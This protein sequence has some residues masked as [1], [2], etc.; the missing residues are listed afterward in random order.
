MD[1]GRQQTCPTREQLDAL[2]S[3][4]LISDEAVWLDTHLA[5]CQ[6]CREALS[7]I[8]ADDRLFSEL[9]A[10]VH[11]EEAS[12]ARPN[13]ANSGAAQN[14]NGRTN[15]NGNGAVLEA[16][17]D[18]IDGYEILEELYRGGQ[19]VIY[20]ALQHAPRRVVVLKVLLGGSF[21]SERE[22][23]RFEREVGLAASLRHPNIVTVFESG[24]AGT[25][26]YFTMEYVKGQRLDQYLHINNSSLDDSLRLFQRI[27]R[28]VHYA[29]QHGVMH[30]DLKPGNI[31]VDEAGE[32]RVLD[33]GLAKSAT[34]EVGPS[35]RVT[36]TGEFMGTL[37]YA[38][39]EQVAGDSRRIDI[40][41]DVY[42]LGVILYEMLT[43]QLPFDTT[44]QL[45]EM[46]RQITEG[47]PARP[48][49]MNPALDVDL[50]IILLKVLAKD[51]ERRYQSAE[52]LAADI[53]RY[54]SSEPIEARRDSTWYVVRKALRRHKAPVAAAVMM[55]TVVLGFA[56]TMTIMYGHAEREATRAKQTQVF[57]EGLLGSASAEN[58]G[59]DV[60]LLEVLSGAEQRIR[61][62]LSDQPEVEVAV[63]QTIGRTYA[64]IRSFSA[65]EHHLRSALRISRDV[66]GSDHPTTADCA[67]LLGVVLAQQNNSLS[68]D[69]QR[70]ALAVRRRLFGDDDSLVAQSTMDLASALWRCGGKERY[71]EAERFYADALALYRE[72]GPTEQRGLARCLHS[73]ASL[74]LRQDQHDRAEPLLAESLAIIRSLGDEHHPYAVDLINDYATFLSWAGDYEKADEL[75]RESLIITPRAFGQVAMPYLLWELG[76]VRHLQHDYV[77]AEAM[78]R[79]SL[80]TS[81]TRLTEKYPEAGDRLLQCMSPLLAEDR[82]A[83]E[84]SAYLR[85]FQELRGIKWVPKLQLAQGLFDVGVLRLDQDDAKGAEDLL[86]ESL[87]IRNNQ[88]P[89]GHVQVAVS[90]SALGGC[91]VQL[92]Q[93]AEAEPLLTEAHTVLKGE[94]GAE[95][96]PTK[97]ALRR[98]IEL[99][100][101][102]KK[103][104][105][106]ASLVK[107]APQFDHITA[108]QVEGVPGT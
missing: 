1:K 76:K 66:Y 44:D 92:G 13:H 37:A 28:A 95:S 85:I 65:A 77:A 61:E 36:M 41:T 47:Q 39:P 60:K 21:A 69:L 78:Y 24:T 18:S 10:V 86:R 54:L 59:P 53:D 40:R 79:E 107:P 58:L 106:A 94:L 3:G 14:G 25:R 83:I 97:T 88:M 74:R 93:F 42:S 2:A 48:T 102:W 16:V 104:E 29:H 100:D 71:P 27:C 64:T 35:R 9:R 96:R 5:E 33:F 32:P 51:R 91:L 67:S 108:P 70:Q 26:P 98:L 19:G 82:S 34:D 75:L 50:E 31:L 103:P 55:M 38:S 99:Y 80:V 7:E 30:R 90:K 17:T 23:Y 22:R 72:A 73:L 56:V 68:I 101:Q 8:K 4:S 57:L 81:C 105:R 89:H 12:A 49:L 45:S 20:K 63:R 15:T 62:E 6:T 43:G 87:D 46:L 52:A 11:A 84:A